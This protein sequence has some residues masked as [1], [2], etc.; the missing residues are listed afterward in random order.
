M[1]P[2]QIKRETEKKLKHS[3]SCII[4]DLSLV[5][6]QSLVTNPGFNWFSNSPTFLYKNPLTHF[7]CT[8]RYE[9]K[10]YQHQTS[11]SVLRLH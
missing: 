1:L 3:S 11:S 10:T 2:L 9:I 5:N 4:V 8:V 6:Y 7:F